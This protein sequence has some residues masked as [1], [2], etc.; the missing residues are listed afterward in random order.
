MRLGLALKAFFRI[1]RDVAFAERAQKLMTDPAESGLEP[2]SPARSE[3]AGRAT[4][5]LPAG[6]RRSE[7]ITLLATLQREA[8]LVDLI[9]E[10]LEGYADAQIGAAAREVLRDSREV[11]DRLFALEPATTAE[12]GAVVEA[13]ADFDAGC[14][15]LTG[16][17]SGTGPFR[18]A[19]GAPRAG[20]RRVANCRPSV[21]IG[22][23]GAGGGPDRT[24]SALSETRSADGRQLM[25]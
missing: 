16:N 20:R 22:R 17:V 9:R 1:L 23:G 13:P 3:Q 10:P 14:Y 25:S 4:P 12:E 21:G 18:G 11:L 6:P 8:R 15:R 2:P 5:R 19:A 7:A 24:G